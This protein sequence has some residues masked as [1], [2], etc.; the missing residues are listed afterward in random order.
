MEKDGLLDLNQRQR[1]SWA[2]YSVSITDG[3]SSIR[4]TALMLCSISRRI[5]RKPS[6]LM[7]MNGTTSSD[8]RSDHTI[9]RFSVW[10][11]K[12]SRTNTFTDNECILGVVIQVIPSLRWLGNL[13]FTC[14]FVPAKPVSAI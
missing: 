6:D 8:V 9:S 12:V 1:Y 4:L 3:L 5:S 7:S 10:H 13:V 14:F 2:L 11:A